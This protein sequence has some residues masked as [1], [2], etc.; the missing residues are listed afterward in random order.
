[1]RA[2]SGVWPQ[3][4]LALPPPLSVPPALFTFAWFLFDFSGWR[5]YEVG[6]Y[7]LLAGS[8]IA[9]LGTL[10]ASTAELRAARAVAT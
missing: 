5:Y 6:A 7:L 2:E 3:V 10:T 9:A 1:M 4:R 8:A